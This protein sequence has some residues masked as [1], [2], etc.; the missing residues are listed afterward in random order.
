MFRPV[1]NSFHLYPSSKYT[2]EQLNIFIH[3]I[4][5]IMYT[6]NSTTCVRKKSLSC[7]IAWICKSH[8]CQE[9]MKSR[10]IIPPVHTIFMTVMSNNLQEYTKSKYAINMH[11]RSNTLFLNE[12]KCQSTYYFE[13][14]SIWMVYFHDLIEPR[15][16]SQPVSSISVFG[17]EKQ[18]KTRAA[19]TIV[20]PLHFTSYFAFFHGWFLK[21]ISFDFWLTQVW[22]THAK[23]EYYI[24]QIWL[25]VK[26]TL[27]ERTIRWNILHICGRGEAQRFLQLKIDW[28]D[29]WQGTWSWK[30]KEEEKVTLKT[31]LFQICQNLHN[32]NILIFGHST[33]N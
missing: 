17:A 10:T 11:W 28:T 23:Y 7:D 32:F 6:L 4:V 31:Q 14:L 13:T 24:V 1:G 15:C 30:K 9:I 26:S 21:P 3:I 29:D 22:L 5:Y 18:M 12:S 19:L 20:T 25:P 2:Y 27:G 16:H 33:F 8:F